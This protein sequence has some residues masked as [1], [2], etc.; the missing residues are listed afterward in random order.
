MR[1]KPE[2]KQI[3]KRSPHRVELT[4]LDRFAMSLAN[5]H[6]HWTPAERRLYEIAARGGKPMAVLCEMCR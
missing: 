6:H 3:H 1:L 2:I 5:Q 4:P